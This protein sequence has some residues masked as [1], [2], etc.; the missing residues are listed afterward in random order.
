MNQREHQR[1]IRAV[2]YWKSELDA[3]IPQ[4]QSDS[5]AS[6]DNLLGLEIP[7]RWAIISRISASPFVFVHC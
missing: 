7:Q 3:F 2:V 4:Y 5:L 1:A 6:N